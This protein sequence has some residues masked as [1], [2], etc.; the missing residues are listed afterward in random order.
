MKEL[1]GLRMKFVLTNM[2]MVTI[3]LGLAFLAMGGLVEGQVDRDSER[4]LARAA[5]SRAAGAFQAEGKV[6]LPYLILVTD[7]QEQIV[8]V[9]GQAWLGGDEE[10]LRL[11]A[12][13]S[14]AAASDGGF[15]EG[16]QLRYLR[17]PQEDGYWIAYV[18]TSLGNAIAQGMWRTLGITGAAVWLALFWASWLLSKWAVAPVERSIKREKQFLADAS[19]ELKTPLTVIMANAQ[20]LKEQEG[21]D[22]RDAGRWLENIGAEAAGMKRLVEEMLVLARSEAGSLRGRFK[23]CCFSDV[24]IGSVLSFEALFYQGNKELGSDV[25]EDITVLGDEGQLRRLLGI[26]LDNAQKYSKEGGRTMVRLKREKGGWARLCVESAGE[27]IPGEALGAVFERFYRGDK[28]RSQGGGYGLG[29]AIAKSIVGAHRGK[30]YA[31][32]RDGVN[33]FWVEL[34]TVKN[35]TGWRRR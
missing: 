11:L 32:S 20:L 35:R 7:A 25:E 30:I 27:E 14:L 18:D 2:A 15:L 23:P 16:D 8:R 1:K 9:E 21:E 17:I 4:F 6:R 29:L 13:K 22:G 12:A 10:G 24:V 26:L 28:A 33:Q 34:R 19:H 5:Q 31:R 3:V